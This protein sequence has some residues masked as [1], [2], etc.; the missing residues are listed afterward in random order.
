MSQKICLMVATK[1]N[2]NFFVSR[3]YM[4]SLIEFS[5]NL[6]CTLSI[7]KTDSKNINEIT[8]FAKLFC[9]QNYVDNQFSYV[10]LKTNL[11]CEKTKN[12]KKFQKTKGPK[13]T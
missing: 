11:N 9:N 8:D 2:K 10:V 7:V 4:K 3:H 1:E 6:N 13:K 12:N 5:N